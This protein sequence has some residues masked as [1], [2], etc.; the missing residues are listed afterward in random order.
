MGRSQHDFVKYPRTPHVFGSEGTTD[1]KRLNGDDSL[2][3]IR[4]PGLVVEEKLDGTNLGIH[5]KK[6]RLVLQNRGHELGTQEH[7]QYDL[8]KS[9]VQAKQYTLSEILADRYIL[10]GEWLYARHTVF[11]TRL[12][13]YFFEFD[14]YD[15][16]RQVFLD[17]DSRHNLLAGSGIISVP[18]LHRGP[19]RSEEELESLITTSLYSDCMAEGVYLKVE[20]EGLTTGRAKYVRKAFIQSIVD[21][22]THWS[23]RDVVPNKL[24]PGADLWR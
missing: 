4:C 9:W 21:S 12:D 24:S 23:K 5:F 1:D 3:L 16:E 10:Y 19:L 7:P 6:G 20:Q 13:H 11:Y 2:T 8:L 18:V 14:M 22:G 17:T 15:K